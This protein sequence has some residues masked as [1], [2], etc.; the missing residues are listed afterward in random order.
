MWQLSNLLRWWK[1]QGTYSHSA[2]RWIHLDTCIGN[3]FH[4][5]WHIIRHFCKGWGG[6]NLLKKQDKSKWHYTVLV[7]EL[8]NISL[9]FK[10]WLASKSVIVILVSTT[11]FWRISFIYHLQKVLSFNKLSEMLIIS[12]YMLMIPQMCNAYVKHNVW[13]AQII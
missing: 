3:P 7:F 5:Q 13:Y 11:V 4:E 8:T 12:W 1:E 10:I 6:K 9:N 2:V